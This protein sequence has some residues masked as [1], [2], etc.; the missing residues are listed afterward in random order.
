MIRIQVTPASGTV[1][2]GEGRE[3]AVQLCQK[4]IH[5]LL[6]AMVERDGPHAVVEF[7]AAVTAHLALDI[8]ETLGTGHAEHIMEC[9]MKA[10]RNR[11]TVPS[12]VDRALDA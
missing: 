10:M 9:A 1:L 8:Q 11:P 6:M 7:Y 3:M 5:P 12:V 2:Q 4:V